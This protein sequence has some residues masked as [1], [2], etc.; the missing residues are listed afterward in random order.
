MRALAVAV[1]ALVCG[2]ALAAC[3]GGGGAGKSASGGNRGGGANPGGAQFIAQADAL[4]RVANRT[5]PARPART[6]QEAVL[7]AR[8]EIRLREDLAARLDRLTPPANLK[9]L[10]GRYRTLTGEIVAGFRQE[11][12]AAQARDTRRFNQID[13]R[14]ASLQAERAKV[15]GA[16]GFK[17]C[18]GAI[19]PRALADPALIR[20]VDQACREANRIGQSVKPR[21]TGPTDTRALAQA[22]PTILKAQRQA[23]GVIGAQHPGGSVRPIYARF[24][25]AFA[26]RVKITG[27]QVAAGRA[28]DRGKLASLN[29]DDVRILT[30]RERPAAQQLGFEVCGIGAGV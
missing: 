14:I 13:S 16:I 15:G 23:L 27:Q 12:A 21:P 1:V 10:W 17:V 4:C 24:S 19:A 25:A 3:G 30:Q 29:A 22:G 2:V 18:G 9:H 28:G 20:Q 7:V 8:R 5:P 11:V 6:S 26:D